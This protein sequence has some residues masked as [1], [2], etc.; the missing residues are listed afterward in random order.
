MRQYTL[1][2]PFISSN[3]FKS[4]LRFV[5][6]SL[7]FWDTWSNSAVHSFSCYL[8][9]T[10]FSLRVMASAAASLNLS[11]FFYKAAFSFWRAATVA[12]RSATS[13]AAAPLVDFNSSSCFITFS[14]FYSCFYS[15]AALSAWIYS[16]LFFWSSTAPAA[17]DSPAALAASSSCSRSEI[18]SLSSSCSL[19]AISDMRANSSLTFA[20]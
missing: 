9:R 1:T 14:S 2:L 4:F 17:D 16:I 18:R 3:S 8:T 19:T 20:N 15:F 12:V 5:C 11:A 13:P 6:S 10:S 7:Y